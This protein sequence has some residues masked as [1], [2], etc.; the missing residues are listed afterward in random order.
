MTITNA[1]FNALNV[2][3]LTFIRDRSATVYDEV[4]G[5]LSDIYKTDIAE[6]EECAKE[7]PVDSLTVCDGVTCNIRGVHKHTLSF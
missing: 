6:N 2:I 5:I 4:C 1:Q 7:I 3:A